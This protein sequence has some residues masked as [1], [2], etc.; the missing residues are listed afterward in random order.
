METINKKSE[1]EVEIVTVIPQQVIPEQVITKVFTLSDLKFEL[2][3]L[4][5]KLAKAQS[6]RNTPVIELAKIDNDI[7]NIQAEID[8]VNARITEAEKQGVK[9]EVDIKPVVDVPVDLPVIDMPV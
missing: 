6:D 2:S 8:K 5:I 3:E 7:A 1:T 4:Q 9:E